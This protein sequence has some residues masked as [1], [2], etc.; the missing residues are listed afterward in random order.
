MNAVRKM[1]ARL[2][3]DDAAEASAPVLRITSFRLKNAVAGDLLKTLV[4]LYGNDKSFSLA[5]D[6]RSNSII[7]R[8]SVARI[9][10]IAATITRLDQE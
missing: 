3:T 7:V 10:E 1:I 9:E 6:S 8:A 2:D 5:A 4:D